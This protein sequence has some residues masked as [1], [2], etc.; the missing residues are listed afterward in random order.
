[1]LDNDSEFQKWK[2]QKFNDQRE[3]QQKLLRQEEKI[4]ANPAQAKRDSKPSFKGFL[5]FILYYG[6]IALFFFLL[7]GVFLGIS[8]T[9][10]DVD[11][12]PPT[13]NP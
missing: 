10:P 6:G 12:L 13:W 11:R 1:M 2:N 4:E 9:S 8:D 5:L 3:L 7:L